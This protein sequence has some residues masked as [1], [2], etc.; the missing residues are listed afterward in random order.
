[1]EVIASHDLDALSAELTR[2]L[3]TPGPTPNDR[4]ARVF[5]PETIVVPSA[6]M[7][8]YVTFVLA[9]ELGG[10]G[11]GDG[12]VANV[13]FLYPRIL[14][15]ASLGDLPPWPD[16]RAVLGLGSSPWD[17]SRLMWTIEDSWTV[18]DGALGERRKTSPLSASRRIAQLFDHYASHRPDMLR[19]WVYESGS[20]EADPTAP[21]MSAAHRWQRDL[22]RDV[23][24]R[25]AVSTRLAV[26]HLDAYRLQIEEAA[27]S[28][29]L[30][31]RLSVFGVTALSKSVRDILSVLAD[32][33][34]ISIYMLH[35][36]SRWPTTAP[37]PTQ[38]SE[39]YL[40]ELRKER[41][42]E[43]THPLHSRW[44]LRSIE[45][46]ALIGPPSF[47]A[48]SEPIDRGTLL[49]ALR[50]DIVDD[51]HRDPVVC[52]SDDDLIAATSDADGTIQ[53]HTCY[54][55]LRQAEALR[56]VLLRA[57]RDDPTLRLRD[58]TIACADPGA[59]AP[60][61]NA[62]LD[63]GTRS[64]SLPSMP[65]NAVGVDTDGHAPIVEAFLSVVRLAMSRCT[66]TELLEVVAHPSV[67]LCFGLD[68]DGLELIAD[69][70]D[71]IAVRHG[72][73]EEHRFVLSGVPTD[74]GLGTWRHA[75]RRIAV[76]VA[77]PAPID[78]EGPGGVVPYD[79][80]G[81]NDLDVFGSFAEFIDRLVTLST[82]IRPGSLLTIDKWAEV[83]L[84]AVDNFI[85]ATVAE[86]EDLVNLRLAVAGLPESALRAG[87]TPGR[88]FPVADLID[89]TAGLF[90]SSLSPF[91]S[92]SE[93]IRV[94]TFDGLAH[95][96]SRVVAVFGA[97]EQAF[98]GTSIDGDDVLSIMPL[99]GE[100]IYSMAGRES[101]IHALMAARDMFIVTCNGAD[102]SNN[103]EIPL[104]VPIREFLE[105]VAAT[106]RDQTLARYGIPA[107]VMHKRQN[108]N[109]MS[110]LPG[111]VVPNEPF[112][113]DESAPRA[114]RL[115]ARSRSD[116]PS[117]RATDADAAGHA[118]SRSGFVDL[119]SIA[120]AI[121]NPIE[122]YAEHTLQIQIPP[123]P[124][125]RD[126]TE[127]N[128]IHGDGILPLTIDTS[129][130]SAEGRNLLDRLAAGLVSAAEAVDGWVSVR[131]LTGVLP[132]GALGGLVVTEVAE[133][134]R[135]MVELLPPHLQDL[136]L[137]SDI[138]CDARFN[139]EPATFRVPR[140]VALPEEEA[141]ALIRV[142]YRRFSEA[143]L[144]DVLLE[145]AAITVHTGGARPVTATVVSRAASDADGEKDLP[146]RHDVELKGAT[147]GERVASALAVFALG[148]KMVEMASLGK[149]PAFER[150]SHEAG[151]GRKNVAKKF[152]D[153][154]KFSDQA[155]FLLGDSSFSD[156]RKEQV[157]TEDAR[158]FG[159]PTASGSRFDFYAR[160][161]WH[162]IDRV[163]SVHR[164]K[165]TTTPQTAEGD[166]GDNA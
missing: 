162:E 45:N 24:N 20:T 31:R 40:D 166:D 110:V 22:Y 159:E 49:G 12:V 80:I 69:W 138:D 165:P 151:S 145:I 28:D 23:H 104:P 117:A 108:Y 8:E 29:L 105:V 121:R 71:E 70:T 157:T 4:L 152:A 50:A 81:S 124:K 5:E 116:V 158:V 144:L 122:H 95:R 133:F 67:A 94:T 34:D 118:R 154:V 128:H 36:T 21:T 54:G 98:A 130:T 74:V 63:P 19:N 88:V 134:V 62:V 84:D 101:F 111:V 164:Y 37:K 60:V 155:K 119:A 96:P 56:D 125:E 106:T 9:S 73:D 136:S 15:M 160:H 129:L 66:P 58:I 146:V 114:H 143:M 99:I 10:T 127:K 3:G 53:V 18:T 14:G 48:E 137:G 115:V 72:L 85:A 140:F 52:T 17:A 107:L 153:D 149:V 77:V 42:S 39:Q 1:M 161:I 112:T 79:T 2:R 25:L 123:L 87:S 61:L 32:H 65:I 102:V 41:P 57:L 46:A 113:F 132:P 30:P 89:M 59:A 142:R 120:R 150:A 97:D 126:F 92:R 76:G 13:D 64:D 51:R 163:W 68:R 75:L 55:E 16:V 86:S 82:V 7:R 90:E 141:D 139:G 147:P 156:V 131:P 148:E 93:A 109:E 38:T 103:K 33:L 6:P 43:M 78:I 47:F 100:P 83:A 135:K 35:S 26:H 27:A 44:C 91:G 11:H